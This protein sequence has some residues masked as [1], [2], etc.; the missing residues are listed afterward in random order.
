MNPYIDLEEKYCA[1]NY[2]PLPLVL[3][4]GEGVYVWD[5]EGKKYIDMMSAY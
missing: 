4:K 5:I 3:T 1:H 2:H